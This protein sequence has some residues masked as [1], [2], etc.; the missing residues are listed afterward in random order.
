MSGYFS[1]NLVSEEGALSR[2]GDTLQNTGK[3]MDGFANFLPGKDVWSA[4]AVAAGGTLKALDAITSGEFL[5][6][7]K[8]LVKSAVEAA[9]A[10]QSGALLGI[11]NVASKIFT[12]KGLITIAG[13]ITAGLLDIGQ[14]G[15]ALTSHAAGIG[16]NQAFMAAQ[17][18]QMGAWESRM[19]AERGARRPQV[20]LPPD[21]AADWGTRVNNARE[22]AALQQGQLG[23]T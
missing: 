23:A 14:G 17:P 20:Y 10:F 15:K 4:T 3:T 2:L 6:A 22:L 9:V 18:R 7:G 1:N 8:L 11:G 21:Q 13:D 19:A 12:G 16:G 5:K